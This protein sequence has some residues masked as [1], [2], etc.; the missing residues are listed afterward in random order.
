[1]VGAEEKEWPVVAGALFGDVGRAFIY[2]DQWDYFVT[3]KESY[4]LGPRGEAFKF[5]YDWELGEEKNQVQD[6]VKELKAFK[7]YFYNGLLRNRL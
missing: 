5:N 6:E 2:A 4:K 1:M 3:E 7:Q